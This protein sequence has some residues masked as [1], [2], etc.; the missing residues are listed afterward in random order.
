MGGR[1]WNL[2]LDNG[3]T[4]FLPEQNWAEAIAE[5]SGLDQSQRLLSKGIQTVDLRLRGQVTV[6]VAEIVDEKAETARKKA[7]VR[8]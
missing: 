1:R 2:Y 6:A 4:V 7:A 8:R 5:V 3:V